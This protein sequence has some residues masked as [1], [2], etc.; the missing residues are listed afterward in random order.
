[1]LGKLVNDGDSA[2]IIA[3]QSLG[4]VRQKQMWILQLILISTIL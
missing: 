2:T 3:C 4:K 1:M